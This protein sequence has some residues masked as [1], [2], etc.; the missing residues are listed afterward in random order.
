MDL[1]DMSVKAR[2]IQ[3]GNSAFVA[4]DGQ[5]VKIETSPQGEEILNLTVPE[6][7]VWS[8]SVNLQITE[9]DA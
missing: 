8:I 3:A 4:T 7:K 2:S 9:V 5:V 1:R 6:G